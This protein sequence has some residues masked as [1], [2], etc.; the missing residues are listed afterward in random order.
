MS[1][2][3]IDIVV[4]ENGSRTVKRNIEDI[5]RSGMEA[6]KGVNLL[7]RAMIGLSVG[8]GL[9]F[10]IRQADA[11]TNLLN[12][13]KLVTTGT[14][15]LAAVND[16]LFASA[17]RTRASY[18]QTAGLFTTLSRASKS[19]GMNQEDMLGITETVNQA[20]AISGTSASTAAAGLTQLGQAMGSGTLRGDELNS[21][22]ENMPRLADAIA[23]GMG[24]TTDKLRGLGAEGKITSKELADALKS[25]AAVVAEE[26]NRMTPTVAGGITVVRNHLMKFIGDMDQATGLSTGLANALLFVGNNFTTFASL[27]GIAGLALAAWFGVGAIASVVGPMLALEAALGST[28]VMAGIFSIAMKA[29]QGAVNG[30]TLAL[31]ANPIGAIAVGLLLAV[32]ALVTFGDAWK[33][34]EDGAVSFLD[35]VMAGLSFVMDGVRFCASFLMDAWAVA[36][37]AI[38]AG[39]DSFAGVVGNILKLI[40]DGVRMAGNALIGTFVFAVKAVGIVWEG[41][42]PAMKDIGTRAING[43]IALVQGGVN[44][45]VGIVNQLPGV[46]LELANLGQLNNENAGAAANLGRNLAAASADAYRDYITP[47]VTGVWD[48]LVNRARRNNASGPAGALGGGGGGSPT[49]PGADGADG[50]GGGAGQTRSGYLGELARETQNALDLTSEYNV[51]LRAVRE[52]MVGISDHLADNKWAPLDATEEA[53]FRTRITLL[54]EEEAIARIR[55]DLYGKYVGTLK[56][57]ERGLAATG[58]LE[59]AGIMNA[60]QAAREVRNLRYEVLAL[61]TDAASGME[62]G[63]LS[64]MDELEDDAYRVERAMV[65]TWQEARG[66]AL[67]YAAGLRAIDELERKHL[68]TLGEK[69]RALRDVRLAYLDTQTDAMSGF[70]RGMLRMQDMTADAAAGIE[71]AVTNAFK[72]AEDALLDFLDTGK[73][74][75]AKFVDDLWKDMARAQ[76]KEHILGPIARMFKINIPGAGGAT[77]G[78][79]PGTPM[80]VAMSGGLGAPGAPAGGDPLTGATTDFGTQVQGFLGRMRGAWDGVINGLGNVFKGGLSGIG[81]ALSSLVKGIGSMMSGGSGGGGWGSL[82]QT[83][84]QIIGSFFGGSFATGGGFTVPGSGGVDSQLVTLRATPGE[85]VNVGRKGSEGAPTSEGDVHLHMDFRGAEVGVEERVR[86]VMAEEAPKL[87]AAARKAAVKDISNAMTRERM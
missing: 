17:N 13:L 30:F 60:Q 4:S 53:Q 59:A 84:A 86:A 21:I 6:S 66:P 55:D 49:T 57:Y 48:A 74:D 47:A 38:T 8:A 28:S 50:Q 71:T 61:N 45:I 58:Q 29:A 52:Q 32:A 39:W 76:I 70:E 73:L 40:V 72:N 18:E 11:Y 63:L 77:L 16:A 68:L 44:K 20:I 78:A 82:I 80:W 54:Q 83:G 26:F 34:T 12:K 1:T 85:R 19:L 35:V 62:R 37:G 7:Q 51:E 87:V 56:D 65:S 33:V 25:Q 24:I 2:E 14:Q 5:G 36:M 9:T 15:N 75:V 10:L 79:S 69:E 81:S 31:A 43:L 64:I 67:D 42:V 46:E 22:L 23:A 41:L 27:I 3:R